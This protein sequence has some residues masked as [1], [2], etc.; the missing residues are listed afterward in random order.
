MADVDGT[1]LKAW[2]E[3]VRAELIAR[4]I[5]ISPP[6]RAEWSLAVSL[7]L[8]HCLPLEPG[9][10]VGFCWPVRGEYDP[11]RLAWTLRQR[12][13]RNALPVMRGR[14]QPLRFRSWYPGVPMEA[15]PM[16]IPHPRASEEV[17][18]DILLIPLVGF[19]RAGDRLGYGGGYFDRTLSL[20]VPQ[21]LAIGVGFDLSQ[22]ENT[23]PQAHDVPMDA[24]VT[25]SGP[26]IVEGGVLR[27]APPLEVRGRLHDLERVRR[28][29]AASATTIIPPLPLPS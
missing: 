8:L 19:G 29:E 5:A 9:T 15:G 27:V 25:E 3:G 28:A 10:V 23:W 4:R 21:P 2:R 22:L 18:P 13:V 1:P 12:G 24:I 20:L 11:R 7:H 26:R 14:A 17:D 6:Q 16:G